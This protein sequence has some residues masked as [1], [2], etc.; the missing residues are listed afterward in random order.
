MAQKKAKPKPEPKKIGVKE[1]YQL[2]FT[3]K[4]YL[5]F[6]VGL[7]VIIIGYIALSMGSITL[8]PILLVLGY[9]VVIPIAIIING[10]RAKEKTQ[11]EAKP[12]T[13]QPEVV[14]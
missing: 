9:C 12:Q 2:P 11:S 13:E 6:A 5:L 1:K 14:S 7:V 10:G 4:N 8:A 3:K